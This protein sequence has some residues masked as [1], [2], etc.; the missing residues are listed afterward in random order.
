MGFKKMFKKLIKP[1]KEVEKTTG[2][3]EIQNEEELTEFR[4]RKQIIFV[5]ESNLIVSP[6]AEALLKNIDVND[7]FKVSSAGLNAISGNIAQSS[8]VNVCKSH[9]IDLADHI[10]RNINDINLKNIDLV[11][12]STCSIRDLFRK[13][14]PELR[15]FTINEYAK[16]LD[17]PLDINDSYTNDSNRIEIVFNDIKKSIQLLYDFI[18]HHDE[19]KN[20]RELDKLIHSGAKEIVLDSDIHLCEGEDS[21]YL[22]GIR[23]EADNIIIDG[24]NHTIYAK[25]RTRIFDCHGK[26]ITINNLHFKNGFSK[27]GGAINNAGELT[28]NNAIFNENRAESG[29]GAINNMAI[30]TISNSQFNEN[31]SRNY[32]GAIHNSGKINM[33]KSIFNKN[34]SLTHGGAIYNFK[35]LDISGSKFLNNLANLS[36]A[37]FNYGELTISKSCI[38]NNPTELGGVITNDRGH[39]KIIDCNI[40]NNKDSKEIIKNQDYLE[41]YSTDFYDNESNCLIANEEQESNLDIFNGKIMNNEAQS[42]I[43][44]EGKHLTIDKTSFENNITDICIENK[45][46]LTL[47]LPKIEDKSIISNEGRILIRSPTDELLQKIRGTGKIDVETIP[48]KDESDFGHLDKL[49]QKSTAKKITLTEDI[50]MKDYEKYFFEGGIELDIDDLVIDGDGKT[51][52]GAG[53]TRIFTVTGKNITLKNI[54]FKNGQSY[55]NYNNQINADG[56]AIKVVYGSDLKIENC[57]FINNISDKNGGIIRN[58]GDLTISYSILNESKAEDYG[59]AIYNTGKLSIFKSEINKNTAKTGGAIYTTKELSISE[60][61]FLENNSEKGGAILNKGQLKIECSAFIKNSSNKY[62]GAI[63]T[64]GNATIEKSK[65]EENR[66]EIAGGAICNG[67]G[68]LTVTDCDTKNNYLRDI[69]WSSEEQHE[70]YLKYQK[71][72]HLINMEAIYPDQYDLMDITKYY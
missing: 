13:L 17:C 50:C 57:N 72:K 52:D 58:N 34:K 22:E 37:I 31:I 25:N 21:T 64:A 35:K 1:E 9:G 45:T 67:D 42:I 41:I 26:N 46:D 38:N 61:D 2:E 68:E 48:K 32:G 15:S 30:L 29:G 23:I 24:N 65:F 16:K 59:G 71:R 43:S 47:I 56:G 36:G 53:I 51:I 55:K 19:S 6:I 69:C 4:K 63:N 60:S 8:T 7:E 40:F 28:L 12:T 44:N 14:N 11:L 18:R 66:A 27:N 70:M 5:C 62:G 3:Q 10:T 33:D 54:I 20:F 39:F 49:I